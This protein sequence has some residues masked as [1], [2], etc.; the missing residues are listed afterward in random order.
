MKIILYMI[1]FFIVALGISVYF[2]GQSDWHLQRNQGNRLP[3]GK[4]I[5]HAGAIFHDQQGLEWE[6]QPAIKNKFHQ[7]K[8]PVNPVESPYPTLVD[9]TLLMD[10]KNPNLKFLCQQENGA[11]Y[12]AILQPD[13]QY[14][15]TGLQQGTYNYAHPGSL[16][17]MT[18][19][20]FLDVLPHFVRSDYE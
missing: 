8:E 15:T 4:L 19:H 17:G 20:T 3:E 6:L 2:M 14:L 9:T 10:V 18:K 1:G 5:H 13:G 11:S 12:E 16:W 7:P